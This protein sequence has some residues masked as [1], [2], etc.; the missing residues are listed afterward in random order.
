[1][2][3]LVYHVTVWL[4]IQVLY[5]THA[6]LD[7]SSGAKIFQP[8]YRPARYNHLYHQ[9]HGSNQYL[10]GS[11]RHFLLKP[12]LFRLVS[13]SFTTSLYFKS[14]FGYLVSSISVTRS[15]ILFCTFYFVILHPIPDVPI[16]SPCLTT[17]FGNTIFA[18]FVYFG[19]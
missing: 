7:F 18:L 1:M 2:G 17:Y 3:S 10:V 8:Y 14:I 16:Y 6:A 12:P 9:P 4:S 5:S 19:S 15:S 11:A 13:S